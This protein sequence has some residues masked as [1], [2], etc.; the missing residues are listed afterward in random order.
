MI[1]RELIL[2]VK[3][4]A[5]ISHCTQISSRGVFSQ[6]SLSTEDRDVAAPSLSIQRCNGTTRRHAMKDRKLFVSSTCC[7]C[8]CCQRDLCVAGSQ[9]AR[10]DFF[11]L[12]RHHRVVVI[13]WHTRAQ[14]ESRGRHHDRGTIFLFRYG[15]I[16]SISRQWGRSRSI[17]LA[18][19]ASMEKAFACCP[20]VVTPCRAVSVAPNLLPTSLGLMRRDVVVRVGYRYGIFNRIH[21]VTHVESIH[22]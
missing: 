18:S 14:K 12:H 9:A 20:H 21:C 16:R 2:C 1:T 13:C 6:Q 11:F 19:S 7:P 4:Q 15:V 3:Q 8:L 5:P 17:D 10:P 22:M